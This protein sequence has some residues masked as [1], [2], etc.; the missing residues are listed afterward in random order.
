MKPAS[1]PNIPETEKKSNTTLA[2]SEGIKEK[3]DIPVDATELYKENFQKFKDNHLQLFGEKFESFTNAK[4]QMR[5]EGE[6]RLFPKTLMTA[7]KSL[8]TA[9]K[10]Y[11]VFLTEVAVKFIFPLLA[12]IA[13][14]LAAIAVGLVAIAAG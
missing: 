8:K 5:P 2:L 3:A 12:A 9:I 7:I 1:N 6:A 13:A 11:I 10:S 4:L 14:G